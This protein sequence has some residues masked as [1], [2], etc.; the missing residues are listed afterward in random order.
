[1][2]AGTVEKPRTI[3][4]EMS[5]CFEGRGGADARSRWCGLGFGVAGGSGDPGSPLPQGHG[6]ALAADPQAGGGG[7]DHPEHQRPGSLRRPGRPGRPGQVRGKGDRP[8]GSPDRA[9]LPQDPGAA[10]TGGLRPPAGRGDSSDQQRP[11]T[12]GRPGPPHRQAR[13]QARQGADRP[14][15]AARPRSDGRRGA[16][17]RSAKASTPSARAT[18]TSPGS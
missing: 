11:R 15:P 14:R 18:S 2:T 1:M 17:A 16:R 4:D 9:R 7:R 12:D 6:R 13:P 10:S 3:L 5:G 8:L